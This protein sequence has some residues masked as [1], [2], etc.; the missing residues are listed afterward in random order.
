MARTKQIARKTPIKT[1]HLPG[2]TSRVQLAASMRKS[3]PVSGGIKTPH[4][5][6]PGTVRY[7]Y[8]DSSVFSP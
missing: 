8:C 6:R 1:V 4:R 2:K 5:F 7:I 3:A